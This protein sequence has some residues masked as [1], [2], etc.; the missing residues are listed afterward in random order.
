MSLQWQSE[1]MLNRHFFFSQAAGRMRGWGQ[2]E[3]GGAGSGNDANGDP[4]LDTPSFLSCAAGR[5]WGWSQIEEGG[6][7]SGNGRNGETRLDTPSFSPCV[8]VGM[9]PDRRVRGWKR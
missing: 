4:T 1:V 2:I 5:V 7:E 9:G 8:H 3:E 6:A